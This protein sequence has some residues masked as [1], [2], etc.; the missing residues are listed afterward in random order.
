MP[1]LQPNSGLLPIF[2]SG[3]PCTASGSFGSSWRS[4]H[5]LTQAAERLVALL[6]AGVGALASRLIRA[7]AAVC[8]G[9]GSSERINDKH[10]DPPCDSCTIAHGPDLG[11][12]LASHAG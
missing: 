6:V 7:I 9:V 8:K 12:Q 11:Q 1:C 10:L 3:A 5:L 2:L 4:T